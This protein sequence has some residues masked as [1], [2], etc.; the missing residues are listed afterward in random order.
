M[1]VGSG[2]ARGAAATPAVARAVSAGTA[3]VVVV[4]ADG[5]VVYR[6]ERAGKVSF[7]A[8]WVRPAKRDGVPLPENT[9]P[10]APY[11]C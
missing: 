2:S 3:V 9:G 7:V 6:L 10:D 8:K 11:R 5:L 4:P 1:M